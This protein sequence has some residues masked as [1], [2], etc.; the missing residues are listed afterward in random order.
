MTIA[1]IQNI[2]SYTLLQSPIR[3]EQLVTTAKERGYQAVALTDVNVTYGLVDFYKKA[4][5]A[6]I[7][8][9]LGMQ[10]R[11]NGLIDSSQK[12]D[13]IVLAKNEDGYE[14]L[15]RLSSA[16][17]LK[18]DNGQR[19]NV[20]TLDDFKKYLGNLAVITPANSQ[21]EL[22]F[23]CEQNSSLGANFL[24]RLNAELPDS[25]TLYLGVYA[26]SAQ[27]AYIDYVHMLSEQFKVALIAVED[28]KYLNPSDQF[29]RKTLLA[30]QGNTQLTQATLLAHQKGSHDLRPVSELQERYH[31]FGLDKAL[32]YTGFLAKSCTAEIVFQAPQLPKFKPNPLENSK[33]YLNDLAQK[34][35]QQRFSGKQ[36]SKNYQDRLN[37]EL[38]VINKMGFDDYFL[39]VWDVINYIHRAH[40]QS[41]PG[42]GSAAGSL[43]AYAL[44]ITQVDPI[45]YGLLFERFLNPA[46]AQMPD[47]DLDIPDDRRDDVISYMFNKYGMDHAAQILTFGTLAA[48]QALRDC[49]RVFGLSVSQANQWTAT[50][51]FSKTKITLAQSYET[52]AQLRTLVASAPLNQLLFKTACGIEGLPRHTSIHAAGLVIS[53]KSIAKRVGLQ[54]GPLN[55]PVTQ[56]TKTNVESLGLL[57]IDFLGLRNLTI[58]AD[59]LKIIRQ[60]QPAFDPSRI[61]LDDQET[62]KLFQ[63]GETDAVFQFE[64]NG[65][66]RVLRSLK[67]D[68]FE[69]VVAVNALYRPGPM[70]N[71]DHFIARKHGREKVVFP[72]PSLTTILKPTYGIMVYQEQVMQTARAFA[73]FSLGEA[74]LLRRA[75]SKKNQAMID[76]ERQRFMEG[77]AQNGRSREVA[78]R[79]Y[80]YIEQFAN[81]GFN[82]SHAVAYSEIAFWLAYFKVHTPGP[83]YTALLNANH[84]DRIKCADYLN[85][86]EQANIT[87][88][89]PDI[90]QSH[91]SYQYLNGKILVG[92]NAIKGIRR[93][94]IAQIE[95]NAPY[96]SLTDFLRRLDLKFLSLDAVQNLIK[97]GCFDK[98]ATNRLSLLKSTP[99]LIESVKMASGNLALFHALEPKPIETDMPTNNEKAEMETQVLG[100]AVTTTPLLAVQKYAVR[101][102][103]KR[104]DRFTINETGV[105][106]GKLIKLKQIRTKKGQTMAFASFA[107]AFSQQE[108]TIFPNVYTK[109][110]TL[111]KAGNIYLLQLRTQSDR[112]DNKKVQYLLTNL[113]QVNFKD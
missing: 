111:L 96:Q 69:D 86:A 17:N 99:Q 109:I 52:S 66:R 3:L 16:I 23:L 65:I 13:L 70:Q 48:K 80:D 8:P 31:R 29:L 68:S 63:R 94:F 43:V 83:F 41:G 97:A 102:Q 2:S 28:V 59:I 75:M 25:S 71:I 90:N 24:R 32:S 34:G 42:R 61:P 112:F 21:S 33:V 11:L 39:I 19:D 4:K 55:I 50:I 76:H 98:L 35:L 22:H 58:L 10:L 107:D 93:D 74:D 91:K 47:I 85:Q 104:L 101:Y 95:E 54:A 57:K 6:G 60:K 72:D 105:G 64:S 100:F 62:L 108:F 26:S 44:G 53:D 9:L 14:N 38:K 103:A 27:K 15:L 73:G 87:I 79:V 51:P 45:V 89:V 20:L 106:V 49:S 36:I 92:L 78:E 56:Q 46:R 77:A 12:F 1:A 30:I 84:A 7:K 67:P 37:Y 5:S 110:A 18:S 82:R 88:Q 81:Y 40:I 113:R